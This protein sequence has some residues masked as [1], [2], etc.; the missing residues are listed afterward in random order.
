[1]RLRTDEATAALDPQSQ[2]KLM[3]LLSKEPEHI[4]CVSVAHR[5]EL[6]R[7]RGEL[8]NEV[9]PRKRK[10]GHATADLVRDSPAWADQD[11][12]E[13]SSP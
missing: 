8:A 7:L 10:T 13:P 11:E 4:T 2:D 12:T 6:E 1:M 3:E 5:P 9:K